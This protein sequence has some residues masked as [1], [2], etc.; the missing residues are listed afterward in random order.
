MGVYREIQKFVEEHRDCGKVTGTVA[1]PTAEGYSVSVACD[2][3]EVL[4]RWVTPESARH[5]LIYSTLLCSS[6]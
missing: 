2:C 1:R 3:G 5:D 6:N 4:N